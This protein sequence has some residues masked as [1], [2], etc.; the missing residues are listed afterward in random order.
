[1]FYGVCV[2]YGLHAAKHMNIKNLMGVVVN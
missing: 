1:M 2:C